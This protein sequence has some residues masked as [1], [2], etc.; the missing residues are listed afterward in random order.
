M[1]DQNFN[2]TQLLTLKHVESHSPSASI[3]FLIAFTLT[4]CIGLHGVGVS[5]AQESSVA[6]K[7]ARDDL[8]F[9]V[10][11]KWAIDTFDTNEDGSLTKAE[12]KNMRGALLEERFDLDKNGKLSFNEIVSA[13][14]KPSAD[15]LEDEPRN[16]LE[17]QYSRYARALIKAYD[18]NADEHLDEE[19]VAVMRRPI[20][21]TVD[22][23]RDG[24]VSFAELF[25]ALL[26]GKQSDSITDP[27]PD[28]RSTPIM[29]AKKGFEL[30][31]ESLS[32]R[33]FEASMKKNDKNEDGKL[34]SNEI[35][36][37]KW[38]SPKW[39]ISDTDN[40]GELSQD[41]LKIRYRRMFRRLMA[42]QK[43]QTNRTPNGS[44]N[45]GAIHG[46]TTLAKDGARLE[47]LMLS[48]HRNS[49]TAREYASR[50]NRS[51]VG[52]TANK[53]IAKEMTNVCVSL[54]LIRLPQNADASSMNR[55][56]EAIEN[57]DESVENEIKQ[58]SQKLGIKNHD[59]LIFTAT[60]NQK[61]S[62]SSASTVPQ[63][64]GTT[65]T[66]KGLTY[67]QQY[68]DIGLNVDVIPK[69]ENER[70]TLQL[71]LA[72]SDLIRI[73]T[74]DGEMPDER[75]VQWEYDS[76]IPIQPSKPSI[77]GTSSSGQQWI[78]VIDAHLQK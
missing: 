28:S 43:A 46:I 78:L 61:T 41:E 19:E 76:Q 16:S 51:S 6:N 44:S 60:E 37:A 50:P 70:I 31:Q 3:S 18:S 30:S 10:Y 24:K 5:F 67:N 71:K 17:S 63:V 48:D 26:K 29:V 7:T 4:C 20:P 47:G 66:S 56:V 68:V 25:T 35:E 8:P 73:P 39:Q 38:S 77:I 54:F 23:S 13:I 40:N 55:A 49:K 36:I 57:S 33:F 69:I 14:R 9:R 59:Q 58:L 15:A 12:M 72:K 21:N 32:A 2:Q 65:R 1:A 45:E 22:A 34:D 52:K 75:I 74:E 27:A 64:T 62:L 53:P 11:T 42:E